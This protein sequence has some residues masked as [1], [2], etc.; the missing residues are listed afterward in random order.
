MDYHIIKGI[1]DDSTEVYIFEN[2]LAKVPLNSLYSPEREA[3]RFIKK[4]EQNGG[5]LIIIGLGNGILLEK[6]VNNAID[7]K[8]AAIIFI[9]PLKDVMINND[10][11]S[12]IKQHKNIAYYSINTFTPINFATIIGKFGSIPFSIK[13]H[14]NYEKIDSTL[15]KKLI[16]EIKEGI[17]ARQIINNT[18]MRFALDWVIEPLLNIQFIN[19]SINIK[20]LKN[21]FKGERA[22]LVA[23]G[24]SLENNL[25]TIEKLRK[26]AYI[27]SV[28]SALRVLI[29]S[30]IEPDFVTTIDSSDVNFYTHFK[31]VNYNGIVIFETRSNSN[32]QKNHNGTL[33]VT[34]AEND[35]VTKQ[36]SSD[37]YTFKPSPSVAVFTL[38]VIEY[39]G[40]S[41]V[42]LIGQ[43]LSLINGDY[44]ASG[45]KMHEGALNQEVELFVESNQGNPVGT[46]RSLK[47]FLDTFEGLIKTFKNGMKIYNLSEYGAKIQGSTFLSPKLIGDL[48]PRH[49]ITINDNK[50][51]TE[52][53][54]KSFIHL[55]LENMNKIKLELKIAE[56]QINNLHRSGVISK[57]D[58]KLVTKKFK[59]LA[60]NKILNEIIMS[61]LTFVFNQVS[62]KFKFFNH[63]ENYTSENLMLL[64]KELLNFYHIVIKYIE[65][66]LQDDRIA[67]LVNKPK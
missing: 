53:D 30:N 5:V 12:L 44:Y 3:E 64:T 33:I 15:T 35:F 43:D 32:I 22:I 1:A 34:T 62:N 20:Q 10:H 48:P 65:E 55:L 57:E 11:I 61:N 47:I 26:S 16:A 21:K 56:K 37:L 54:G 14:P 36:Y 63:E 17:E 49:E 38:Q 41:E 2:E 9:E 27:F 60:S 13:L 4:I 28:G 18:E 51:S 45:V 24:P 39:L 66:V 23:A 29:D 58:M 59:K 31:D 19:S 40:F 50:I 6:I 7:E 8:F 46:T 67:S 25:N 42:F 52:T